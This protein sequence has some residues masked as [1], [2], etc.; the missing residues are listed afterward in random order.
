MTTSEGDR[1]NAEFE[2]GSIQQALVAAKE[3]CRKAEEESGRLMDERLS[4]L[5]ELGAT[6]DDFEASREKSFA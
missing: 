4:Q 1:L 3:A 2:L 5:M 6:K